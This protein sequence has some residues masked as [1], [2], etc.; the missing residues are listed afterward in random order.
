MRE[1]DRLEQL[2]IKM[3]Y[4]EQALEEQEQRCGRLT[5]RVA[6]LEKQLSRL[7]KKMDDEGPELHLDDLPPHY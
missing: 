7:Y 3:M 2:E 1:T 4:L 5:E 6:Q